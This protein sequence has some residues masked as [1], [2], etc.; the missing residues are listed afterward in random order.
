MAKPMQ[1]DEADAPASGPVPPLTSA[2]GDPRLG[3]PERPWIITSP[4]KAAA[5]Q[6]GAWFTIAPDGR[7][8]GGLVFRKTPAPRADGED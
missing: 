2:G 1:A 7:H 5:L 6:D 4:E 8:A 3:S